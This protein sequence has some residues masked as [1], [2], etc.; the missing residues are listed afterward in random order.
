[1]VGSAGTES[2]SPGV[3]L[4]AV[5]FPPFEGAVFVTPVSDDDVPVVGVVGAVSGAEVVELTVLFELGPDGSSPQPAAAESPR[6][7]TR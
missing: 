3:V 1:V 4:L 5:E 2:C 6:T 7:A